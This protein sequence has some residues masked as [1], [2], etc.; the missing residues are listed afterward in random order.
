VIARRPS[1][2]RVELAAIGGR[3]VHD[4]AVPLVDRAR[5]E[6][7]LQRAQGRLGL[8]DDEAARGVAVEAV[9]D[10][11]AQFAADADQVL[12]L[13]EQA[14]H[15]GGV[16]DAGPRVDRDAGRL[17]D[18]QEVR[19]VVE[20]RHGQV[21]RLQLGRA[22]L[23]QIDDDRRAQRRSFG[24]LRGAAIDA[25]VTLV[26]QLLDPRAR[27]FWKAHGEQLV[28]AQP[29]VFVGDLDGA[30]RGDRARGPLQLP[31]DLGR[32]ELRALPVREPAARAHRGLRATRCGI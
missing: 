11:G 14:V 9:D 29:R 31:L 24:R 17:V 18:D 7:G 16:G 6:L 23:G 28:E 15:D 3:A 5:L 32:L 26:D 20:H 2:R 30:R 4:G 25:D 22:D 10:A 27:Q 8:G 21:D 12:H 19:V 13:M 1:V